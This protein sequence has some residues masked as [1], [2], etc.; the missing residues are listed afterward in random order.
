MTPSHSVKFTPASLTA[1]ARAA[2]QV[3]PPRPADH[4]TDL[5]LKWWAKD[6]EADKHLQQNPNEIENVA[7]YANNVIV[8]DMEEHGPL[9]RMGSDGRPSLRPNDTVDYPYHAWLAGGRNKSHPP[10][11]FDVWLA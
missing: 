1:L 6:A 11:A 3:S 2:W 5:L 10:Q 8:N 7:K 9:W 4:H